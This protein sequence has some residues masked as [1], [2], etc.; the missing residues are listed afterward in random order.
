[1][2][3]VYSDMFMCQ[4]YVTHLPEILSFRL[5]ADQRPGDVGAR[6]ARNRDGVKPAARHISAIRAA[7]RTR[8]VPMAMV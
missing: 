7:E 2:M 1:M 3:S 6:R 8:P 5:N 4:V